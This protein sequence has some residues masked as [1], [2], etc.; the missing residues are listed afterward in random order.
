MPKVPSR[1]KRIDAT[2]R[3]DEDH[4]RGGTFTRKF[5]HRLAHA[6]KAYDLVDEQRRLDA[7]LEAEYNSQMERLEQTLGSINDALS[8]GHSESSSR[9]LE[10]RQKEEDAKGILEVLIED[11]REARAKITYGDPRLG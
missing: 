4:A 10:H 5:L 11:W 3:D 8:E 9:L 1:K 6:V 7:S 2:V